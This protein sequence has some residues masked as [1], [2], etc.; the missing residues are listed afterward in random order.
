MSMVI[1]EEGQRRPGVPH[2]IQFDGDE[3]GD[4]ARAQH[5]AA[6]QDLGLGL[7][8]PAAMRKHR[9]WH[10]APSSSAAIR[11]GASACRARH[12]CPPG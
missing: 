8:L 4:V 6:E 9:P 12:R 3:A 10:P 7:D 1:G 11:P 2:V 5:L